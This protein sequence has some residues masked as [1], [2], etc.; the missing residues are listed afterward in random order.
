MK[1]AIL[2][3]L[4]GICLSLGLYKPFNPL[5]GETYQGIYPDGTL[6]FIEHISHHPPISS[7]LIENANYKMS[8]YYE[9]RAKTSATFNQVYIVCFGPN[10]LTIKNSK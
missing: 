9:Y 7:F 1:N 3:V 2:F 6:V 8:G 10:K 5:L 4:S